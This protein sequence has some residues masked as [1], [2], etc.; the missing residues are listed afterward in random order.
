MKD[1]V[2]LFL[3]LWEGMQCLETRRWWYYLTNGEVE[4]KRVDR[5]IWGDVNA[6]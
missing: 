3:P 6:N 2:G 4:R 5:L 1:A